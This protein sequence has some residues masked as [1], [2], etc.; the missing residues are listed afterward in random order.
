VKANATVTGG[1]L[2]ADVWRPCPDVPTDV[3]RRQMIVDVGYAHCE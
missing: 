1:V 2:Q 3:R